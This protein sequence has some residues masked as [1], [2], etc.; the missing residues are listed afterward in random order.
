MRI[1][2]NPRS[3]PAAHA[4]PLTL[5]IWTILIVSLQRRI[6]SCVNAAKTPDE[7]PSPFSHSYVSA[8][9]GS[10]PLNNCTSKRPKS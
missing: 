3:K 4:E 7:L 8:A 10:S 1:V 9:W 2:R 5:A 6:L